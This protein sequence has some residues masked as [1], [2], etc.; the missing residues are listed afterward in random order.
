MSIIILYCFSAFCVGNGIV[1]IF[2][3]D[4]AWTMTEWGNDS[5]GRESK[6]TDSWETSSTI[7]GVIFIIFGIVIAIS[8]LTV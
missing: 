8:G 7:G 3:K 5:A 6:R 2:F 1:L 4:T